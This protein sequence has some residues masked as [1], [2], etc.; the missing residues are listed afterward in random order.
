LQTDLARRR[1]EQLRSEIGDDRLVDELLNAPQR[2][3]IELEA[4]QSRM[5]RLREILAKLDG[6]PVADLKSVLDHLLRR[7]VWIVG[8]DGWAYDIGAGGLDHVLAS[9]RDVNVLVLDT[10]TY[11]NTGGQASKS[12]PLGAVAKFATA[13]KTTTKKDLAQQAMAYG[14]VYVARVAMGADPQQTLTA[15]R[16][17]EAYD[18]PSLI[19]AYS[20]CISHGIP[21]QDGLDQQYKAVASG[22]WPLLRYDPV[23]RS[24]GLNP[25][26][27]DSPRPRLS[28]AEYRKDELRFKMLA[29]ADPGEA[30][31]LSEL[32]QADVDRRWADYE[33][34]ANR[35]ASAFAADARRRV[36][37]L[38]A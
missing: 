8:G 9:G 7:S 37:D 24:E 17:A 12:T 13:G 4:Q 33:D 19:I 38:I 3:E 23:R 18:G 30:T 27:L 21:M 20:H 32:A 31:R 29:Q 35:P 1:L 5:D 22:Y 2:S 34:L 14:N 26:L 25:F 16:E 28:L 10:E 11:S 36:E 15:F 6:P